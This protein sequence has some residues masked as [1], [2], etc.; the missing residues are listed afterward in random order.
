MSKLKAAKRL[1]HALA[2]PIPTS[3]R[4]DLGRSLATIMSQLDFSMSYGDLDDI[5]GRGD[6][7][8]GQLAERLAKIY[9]ARYARLAPHGSS[10]ANMAIAIGLR[11]A[12]GRAN[13]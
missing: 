11:F 8:F 10:L 6:G 3:E 12:L 13:G 5:Q 9:G 2:G 4:E 1:E 7:P